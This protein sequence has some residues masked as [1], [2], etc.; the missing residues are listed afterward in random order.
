MIEKKYIFR[1]Q[2]KHSI[3]TGSVTCQSPSNIALVKYW[4]KMDPQIPKNASISL[5]LSNCHTKT[6][7]SYS[8]KKNASESYDFRVF[9]DGLEQTDFVPKIEQFFNRIEIYLPFIKD[10]VFEIHTKNSFPHSSGIAS[11]ASG[12]SALSLCL[13]S[14]QKRI[15]SNI[16][17]SDFIEKTSFLSRLGSGSAA[18]SLEGP[19][20]VWG[21][22]P[23]IYG[24]SDLFGIKYPGLIHKAF[25]NYNDT[26]LLVDKGVKQVSSTVG[27][28]LMLD[29]PFAYA[30]FNQA[31]DNMSRMVSILEK[32]DLN[33]FIDVVEKEA[34]SLHAMMMTSNPY[35]VLMKPNTLEIIERIWKFRKTSEC[36][37]CFTLDAGANV[38]VLFP[39]KD[40]VLVNKFIT[41]N[42]AMFCENNQ[43]ICD[44]V[45]AGAIII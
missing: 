24:S 38:H 25:S 7:L 32:G 12:M 42:L 43:Y 5:T 9:L 37:I 26:I 3:E 23:N 8:L 29:H 33:A 15:D 35:F 30:R 20:V 14:L 1:P 22:H 21:K 11:S 34:L 6:T 13:M 18:R 36:H 28:K 19:L 39:D 17:E 40:K 2:S 41:E 31:Q 4:G 16:S 10:Y 44:N 45:G 27:H